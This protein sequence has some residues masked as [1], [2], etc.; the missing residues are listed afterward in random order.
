MIHQLTGREFQ[1][2]TEIGKY[3]DTHST[4]PSY[5]D[6][7]RCT[8]LGRAMIHAYVHRLVSKGYITYGRTK[9]GNMQSRS[10]QYVIEGEET[11]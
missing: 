8:G 2:L 6:L 10:I 11:S 3:L 5:D 4:G 1:V 7:C 9:N